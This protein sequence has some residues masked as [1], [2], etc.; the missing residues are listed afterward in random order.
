MRQLLITLPVLALFSHVLDAQAVS[1]EK[2]HADKVRIQQITLQPQENS[3]YIR[4]YLTKNPPQRG[5]IAGH[6]HIK[7]R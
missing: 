2:I 5:H 1:S 7:L 6:L 3:L 4:G